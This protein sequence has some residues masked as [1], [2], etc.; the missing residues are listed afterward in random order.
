MKLSVIVCTYRRTEPVARL[1]ACLA[2]QTFRDFEVLLVDGAG[3]SGY[4]QALA[5]VERQAPGLD[6]RVLASA[7]GLTRQRN[8]GLR[9]S[10]GELICLLDDDVSFEPDFLARIAAAFERPGME[11]V[12]GLTGYDILHYPQAINA[13]W[14]LRRLLRIVPKLEPGAIDRLGASVP[15]SFCAPFSGSKPVG[16]FYGFCMVYRQA[17]IAGLAF[18]EELPTYGGEDRDFSFRVGREWSLLLDGD[19]KLRHFRSGESRDSSVERT[20]QTG[21]G[22]GRTFAKQRRYVSDYALLAWSLAG[23]FLIDT[24][25]FFEKP[26]RERASMPFARMAGTFAG[27]RSAPPRPPAGALDGNG[28]LLTF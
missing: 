17:A 20:R 21:F 15:V 4:T 18:D 8:A 26:S 9:A 10:R 28:S 14:R 27:V 3:E 13:R 11:R 22:R 6:I 5:T 1:L 25:A 7:K 2:R 23:E 16:F 19:L 12:G 24:L